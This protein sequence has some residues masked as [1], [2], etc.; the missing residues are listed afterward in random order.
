MGKYYI[1]S[2]NVWNDGNYQELLNDMI[3]GH[4]VLMGWKDDTPQGNMFSNLEV[5]DYI[6]VAKRDNWNW[7]YFFAGI[8]DSDV[9]DLYKDAKRRHLSNFID[10]RTKYL[11][12]LEDW[13]INN[14]VHISSINEINPDNNADIIKEIENLFAL[15]D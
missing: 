1:I 7:K 8:I 12:L 11:T 15:K 6:V 5:G 4:F 3:E 14:S 9:I 13:S 2:P 10:L